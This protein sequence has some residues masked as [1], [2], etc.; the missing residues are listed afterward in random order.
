MLFFAVMFLLAYI[1]DTKLENS[2]N[3]ILK[4]TIGHPIQEEHINNIISD[5]GANHYLSSKHIRK[6]RKLLQKRID[7]PDTVL[8]F[9]TEHKTKEL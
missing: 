7:N 4:E 2:V 5:L 6:I 1:R 3:H 8:K 9:S